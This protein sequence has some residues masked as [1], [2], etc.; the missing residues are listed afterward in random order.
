MIKLK[1]I[2]LFCLLG[3]MAVSQTK[4]LGYRIEGNEVVFTFDSRD[5][6]KATKD[7]TAERLDFDD[8]DIYTISVSGEFNNWSKEG[9]KMR[10]T[11]PY[12]FELRKKLKDFTDEFSW[13][14]K[15]IVN[16]K[17]WAEPGKTASNLANAK[18]GNF[19]LHVYNLKMYTAEVNDTGNARFHLPGHL[20]AKKVILAGSFN[21]WDENAFKMKKGK[22]GW[23]LALQLKPDTYQYKFI[24]DGEWMEDFHNPEKVRNEFH[25]YNSVIT[26]TKKTTFKL[27]G[28]QNA[29]K[30]VLA[31]S[32]NDWNEE[33][34]IMKKLDG[35]WQYSLD[36]K[37]GKYHY[38]FIVDGKWITD[39]NNRMREYDGHGNINSVKLV[40]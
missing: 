13:E 16:N 29:Q 1:V 18:K 17:Y 11:G 31:G 14:F 20:N 22:N 15:Y 12:T 7:G 28:H 10:R 33:K 34:L 8:L 36:L 27:P 37:G 3:S 5:Y 40:E 30:V 19:W 6:E 2:I 26:I 35:S 4:T 25:G 23:T 24:V 21:R 9:W 39:P 38:K 32:F